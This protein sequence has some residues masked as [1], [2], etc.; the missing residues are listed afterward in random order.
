MCQQV[1]RQPS[2]DHVRK[3]VQE[4]GRAARNLVTWNVPLDDQGIYKC[5]LITTAVFCIYLTF[6]LFL[7]MEV[8]FRQS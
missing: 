1:N 4:E 8:H 5:L 2:Y 6:S 7:L 3:I